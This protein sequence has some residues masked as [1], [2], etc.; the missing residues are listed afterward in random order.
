MPS[1]SFSLKM[2]SSG[3]ISSGLMPASM[4]VRSSPRK[5]GRKCGALTTTS[6]RSCNASIT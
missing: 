5:R 2:I 1:S 3:T 4:R 6:M